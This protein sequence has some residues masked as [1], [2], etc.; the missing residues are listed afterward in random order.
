MASCSMAA[1]GRRIG[2]ATLTVALL[3]LRPFDFAR[4]IDIARTMVTEIPQAV[5][6]IISAVLSRGG[7]I[8]YV[9]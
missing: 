4:A 3:A 5:R 7:F 9:W 8:Y 2:R 6:V 1:G